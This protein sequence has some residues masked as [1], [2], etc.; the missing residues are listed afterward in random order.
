MSR[1]QMCESHNS[2]KIAVYYMPRKQGNGL[3]MPFRNLKVCPDCEF[4]RNTFRPD[5]IPIVD[6]WFTSVRM[7]SEVLKQ[8]D[9]L[10]E[11]NIFLSRSQFIR[12]AVR[13]KLEE[14]I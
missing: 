10:V 11:K 9:Y 4:I 14:W 1:Y 6:P 3:R 12:E 7:D 13:D 5:P 8:I 2:R